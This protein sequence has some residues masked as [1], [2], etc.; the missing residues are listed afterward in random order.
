[1]LFASHDIWTTSL[2]LLCNSCNLYLI[3]TISTI[4]NDITTRQGMLYINLL[5]NLSL[6]CYGHTYV[7][8]AKCELITCT[9]NSSFAVT[10]RGKVC[11]LE[12][13][14]ICICCSKHH[15]EVND[16]CILV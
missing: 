16:I 13:E 8:G 14:W 5:C 3:I 15:N 9:T 11:V 1:M 10:D 12:T 2:E 4:P 7:G 6:F